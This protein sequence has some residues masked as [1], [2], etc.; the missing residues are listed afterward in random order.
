[1]IKILITILLSV[2]NCYRCKSQIKLKDEVKIEAV[3]K[4]SIS[5]DAQFDGIVRIIVFYP[6]CNNDE[7]RIIADSSF[8]KTDYLVNKLKFLS[9]R[10]YL[11]KHSFLSIRYRLDTITYSENLHIK[12]EVNH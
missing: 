10:K 3:L 8:V 7:V 12:V 4:K 11:K 6:L 9:K 1:M 5:T 2:F